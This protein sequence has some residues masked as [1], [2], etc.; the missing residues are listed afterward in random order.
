[1]KKKKLSQ[2]P[3]NKMTISHM[4]EH[5]KGGIRYSMRCPRC[6]ECSFDVRC[7]TVRFDTC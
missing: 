1:M 3:F 7:L 2:L 6:E 5:L 4:R